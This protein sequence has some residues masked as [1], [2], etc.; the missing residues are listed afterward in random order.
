MSSPLQA[1]RQETSRARVVVRWTLG[2]VFLA[3]GALKVGHPVAFHADLLA[4]G[5]GAPDSLLRFLAVALPWI[6]VVSGALLL[7]GLWPETVGVVVAA[8]CL[9]FVI[10]LAQAVGRGLELSCGCFGAWT[11][12]WFDRPAV[13]LVRSAGLLVASVWLVLRP[14]GSPRPADP[15]V[16]KIE[17]A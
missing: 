2:A 13:A 1:P 6:E 9:V 8:L 14:P 15:G 4:Y 17:P 5:L 10:A 12:G 11:P 3:A 16:V 7:A